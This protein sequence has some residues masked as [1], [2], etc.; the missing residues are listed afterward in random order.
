METFLILSALAALLFSVLIVASLLSRERRPE[1]RMAREVDL[2]E[3]ADGEETLIRSLEPPRASPIDRTAPILE[4]E[5]DPQTRRLPHE[6][7]PDGR[8]R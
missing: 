6:P 1:L 2:V 8:G 5:P 4:I 7:N 3:E